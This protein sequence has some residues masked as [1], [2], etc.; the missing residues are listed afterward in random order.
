MGSGRSCPLHGRSIDSHANSQHALEN[1]ANVRLGDCAGPL[2]KVN[3]KSTYPFSKRT[4]ETFEDFN[5]SPV[6][7]Q[8]VLGAHPQHGLLASLFPQTYTALHFL[9]SRV[10]AKRIEVMPDLDQDKVSF[11]E[12]ARLFESVEGE[13]HFA[14]TFIGS[15]E[16]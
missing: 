12:T 13:I 2:K 10:L 7:S 5:S 6:F 15:D 14:K 1:K 4:H 11:A 3:S 9:E 16:G 8:K